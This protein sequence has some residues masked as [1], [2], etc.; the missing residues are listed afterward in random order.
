MKPNRLF[1][2]ILDH[3]KIVLGVTLALTVFFLAQFP[4][5]AIDTDPKHMLPET[6]PVRQYNDQVERDF[7]LHPD[8]IVLGIVNPE[9][10]FNV[11]TLTRVKELTR[12]IQELPGVISR[13]V[14]SL[15]TVDNITS[16]KGELIVKPAL[17]TVPQSGAGL[18]VLRK[19]LLGNPLFVNRFVSHD[20]T[21]LA[22]FIP[23]EPSVNGKEIADKIRSLLPKDSGGD[24]FYLAGDPV[25]R[26]TFGTEM[27]RQMALFSPIA[28]MVMCVAL[29]FMFRNVTVIIANMTVAMISIIWSMGGLIAL[30][31]PVHIMSSMS[32]V[33]LMAIATDAVHIF[34]EFAFR[35]REVKDKRTAISETMKV[36]GPPVFY[37]DVTTAVGFAALATGAIVPLKIF[38]LVIGFGTL[39]ILVM[40]YTLVPAVLMLIPEKHILKM[41]QA[42]GKGPNEGPSWLSH[43]GKFCVART[44]P[45]LL[46]GFV[47]FVVAVAGLSQI[48]VNNNMVHWFKWKSVV[49]TADRVMNEHL[50]GTSTAYL[51]IQA[52]D[53]GAIGKPALLREIEGL[54]RE[55][56]KDPLVGKT[57]SAA[58]YVKRVNQVLHDDS[59]AFDRIPDSEREVGQYLFLLQSAAKPRHLDN[60]VDFSAKTANIILQLKSWDAGVMKKVIARA[61]AFLKEHPLPEGAKVK[62]AGIAYFNMVW[63]H[64]VLWGML[65]SFLWGLVL[66]L[67]LL[68]FETR[69]FLWGCV[70]FLPLLFTIALIY[71]VVGLIGKDFDMPVAVLSTL[72]LGMAVDFAIHFVS[73]F[74]QRYREYPDLKEA[75]IWTV[76]RPGKG[77]FLNAILFALGFAVMGFSALTP[78]ITVG[79]LMAAIMILSSVMSVVYL[80]ALIHLFRRWL[81]KTGPSS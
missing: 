38:G 50:G 71:G 55:L 59:P 10:V 79:I 3:P 54:Q 77:I 32:P 53:E 6:S 25:A 68:V 78:Y 56:E 63:N 45:I 76:A 67:A 39:V 8:V 40:S 11:R 9:G 35:L 69:S 21:T 34:N 18:S 20:A 1:Q 75:L 29:W 62:P 17:G 36:V 23:I 66:V 7:A 72:S 57:F 16:T 64:E 81:L 43:L 70:S 22:L 52:K 31:Y 37:S 26:D 48:R 65:T 15:T 60:V 24:T 46:A 13:D 49:R 19:S 33:F 27:F 44:K 51:V 4:K 42:H 28:G 2:L 80:P 58:D 47:L 73:R 5:I 74:Q 12:A 41:A 61:D 30:G 14:D